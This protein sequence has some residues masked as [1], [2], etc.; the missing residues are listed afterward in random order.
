M[1]EPAVQRLVVD[2][3]VLATRIVREMA[4]EP[5]VSADRLTELLSDPRSIVVAAHI[6]GNP[7]GYLVAYSFP[8]LRGE[9]LVYLYDIEVETAYRRQGIATRLVSELLTVCRGMGV[10]SIWVGSSLTN[11]AACELWRATGAQ[12][13]GDQYVE[14]T[15]DLE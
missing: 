8:S 14:F 1:I 12:R 5:E 6:R 2:D 4:R 9:R 11:I 13:D 10:S 3:L 7:L 15:Y